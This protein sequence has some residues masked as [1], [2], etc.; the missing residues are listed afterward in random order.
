MTTRF[1]LQ[2]H[3]GGFRLIGIRFQVLG[4]LRS[5]SGPGSKID[6][7]PVSDKVLRFIGIQFMIRF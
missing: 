2:D 7:D 5:S 4:L 1:G 6:R 3:H